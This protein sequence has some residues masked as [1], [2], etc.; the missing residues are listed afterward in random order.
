ML[1]VTGAVTAGVLTLAAARWAVG[2]EQRVFALRT[3]ATTAA[4]LSIVTPPARGGGTPGE[5]DLPRLLVAVRALEALSGWTPEVEV[6]RGTA[7]LVHATAPPLAPE[8]FERLRRL[9]TVRW[10]RGAALAPLKDRDDWDVVGAVKVRVPARAGAP[11]WLTV[12]VL[13]VTLGAGFATVRAIRR[14]TYDVRRSL[15][16]YTIAAL[17]LGCSAYWDIRSAAKAG[18]DRWL[19]D[20][21]LLLQEAAA[22]L[23]GA[24]SRVRLAELARLARGAELVEADS[25]GVAPVRRTDGGQPRA[26]VAARLG[27]GRWVELRTL[28]AEALA[29]RWLALLVGVALLGP[30]ATWLAVWGVRAAARPQRLRETVTAWGF[31]APAV[32]HLAVFSFGPICFALYLSVHRWGLI[33]P[34]RPFV[35]LANFTAVARDP[36]VWTSVRNTLVYALYVPVTMAIALG[37][38]VVLNRHSGVVRLARTAFFLPYVSSVV[39]IALMWQWMFHADFGVLNYLLSFVGLGPVDWLG[40]PKTALLAVMLMSVWVQVGYQMVVFLAGLQG[41]PQAYLDAARVDGANAWQR[42]W[43]VTFP[44]LKPVTLFV[45]VTG[46]IGSFQVFTYI[47]VLTDG[48]PLH[49]TD[50]IVYRIYQTAWEF[51]QFGT[52]SALSLVLFLILFGVTWVQFRLLGKRVE[53]V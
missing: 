42:F 28:P 24:A 9:E 13:L 31:L 22:R 4:Y 44:L 48:G 49:A 10:Q 15:L 16:A 25:A 27:P 3:A 12:V 23:P 26:A 53:Y 32:L 1:A 37:V 40:S 30:A 41:I 19:S 20:T 6:Y 46:V 5:Y 47:Y 11:G 52:A 50:V 45:L 14:T 17:A 39:A 21:R 34:G 33:E 8:E 18:T 29:G 43:R 35:G 38:A 2:R 7:P 51:L 36:L